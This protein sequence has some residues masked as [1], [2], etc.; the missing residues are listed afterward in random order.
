MVQTPKGFPS[1]KA[2]NE[3]LGVGTSGQKGTQCAPLCLHLLLLT[4]LFSCLSHTKSPLPLTPG[5]AGLSLGVVTLLPVHSRQQPW[6]LA[7]SRTLS[8]PCGSQ[9]CLQ[10]SLFQGTE[11]SPFRVPL[12]PMA[13][14]S[15]LIS[16]SISPSELC[17]HPFTSGHA[18]PL[19]RVI[20]GWSSKS[21]SSHSSSRVCIPER[22]SPDPLQARTLRAP[23]ARQG[24]LLCLHTAPSSSWACCRPLSEP[25]PESHNVLDT[26]LMGGGEG[27]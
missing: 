13:W 14:P 6:H 17:P 3:P 18:S 19:V 21:S 27:G 10:V 1:G 11:P 24:H 7:Q 20:G 9:S 5:S 26:L 4:P 16:P 23:V 12:E 22:L 2:S 15:P 25:F 8:S